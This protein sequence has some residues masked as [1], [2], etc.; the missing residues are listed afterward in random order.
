MDLP[1]PERQA[2]ATL[3]A[4]FERLVQ[5][6]VDELNESEDK[7]RAFFAFVFGGISGLAIQEGLSPPQAHAVAIGLFC[8]TLEISPM[9]SIRMA[10]L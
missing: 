3:S 9:D 7:R 8:E 5:D 6:C 10:Q 2:V 1:T 4:Y